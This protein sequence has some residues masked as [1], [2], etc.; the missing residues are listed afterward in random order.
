MQREID[1]GRGIE[2]KYI[3]IDL[4]KLRRSWRRAMNVPFFKQRFDAFADL[5]QTF[6]FVDID[7]DLV[8]V[9]PGEHFTMGGIKTN[10]WGETNI[11]G[12]FAAGECACTGV[13]GANR[14]GANALTECVIFGRRAGLRAAE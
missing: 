6:A 11:K 8:P 10:I 9:I 5:A 4:R 12:L 1:E 7:K 3:G 2:G 13:Q 14:E